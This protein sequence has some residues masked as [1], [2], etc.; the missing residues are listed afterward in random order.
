MARETLQSELA[1]LDPIWGG[2]FQYSTDGDWNHPHFEK[3]MEYQAGVL[4]A[5]AQAYARLRDSQWLKAAQA[6]HGYLKTFLTSP[7]GAFYVSQDADLV[8]G[9]HSAAYFALGDEARRK[10]GI[11]RVD[12][13]VY[14][15][16]NGWAI[17]ALVAL[18]SASG[19]EEALGD[20][21]KAAQWIEK[22]RSYRKVGF[23]HDEDAKGLFLG[24]TLAMGKAFLALY[25]ATGDRSWLKKAEDASAF[26][27][28]KFRAR[29]AGYLPLAAGSGGVEAPPQRGENVDV[30]RFANLLSQYTGKKETRAV[31]ERA[32]RFLAT[33]EVALD[34]RPSGVLLAAWELA[35]AP[36]HVT[37]VGHKDDPA[38]QELFKAAQALPEPYRRIDWWDKREGPMPNPDT[39]YPE[40]KTAAAFAC[41]QGRCSLPAFKPEDV[42]KRV[43]KFVE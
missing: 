25:G 24:D 22:H 4:K 26:I 5:Y 27:D 11:P 6:I 19:D 43:A 35:R 42:A 40:M 7:D 17:E 37:I 39:Q 10:Q 3:I 34:R 28:S 18:Y 16:E 31:A 15:R 1:L 8:P 29:D 23:R 12:K 9:E 36:V 20:A 14:S 21:V 41:A 33:P 30:A 2:V 32:M 38:A 13:H